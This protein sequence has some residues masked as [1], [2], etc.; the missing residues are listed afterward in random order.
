MFVQ[1]T[2]E[3]Y[4]ERMADDRTEY[5]TCIVLRAWI[6][7]WHGPV[8]IVACP[9]SEVAPVQ[10]KRTA[11][12]EGSGICMFWAYSCCFSPRKIILGCAKTARAAREI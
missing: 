2:V 3:A 9:F 7:H 11:T 12:H 4:G 10:Q 8:A 5:G 1:K 6:V